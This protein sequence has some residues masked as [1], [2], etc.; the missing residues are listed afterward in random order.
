M[1]EEFEQE[2][3]PSLFEDD[4]T[5]D[6][7]DYDDHSNDEDELDEWPEEDDEVE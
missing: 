4:E 5:I 1:T 3:D 6:D 7:E 2:I